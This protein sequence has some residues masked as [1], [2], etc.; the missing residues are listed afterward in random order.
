VTLPTPRFKDN[1]DGT[2]TDRLTGLIWLKNVECFPIGV[3]W[4]QA[5]RNANTLMSGGGNCNLT[6]G[7]RP[8]DW[9]VPNIRELLSLINFG[10]ADPAL[11]NTAGT[12]HWASGSP[13]VGDLTSLLVWTST[14]RQGSPT[15]AWIVYTNE[16]FTN[17]FPKA[18][19]TNVR[20]WPVRGG[21]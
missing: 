19:E 11:G 21:K 16:G 13:F 4:V 5:L 20:V 6:D 3:P 15:E 1:G 8:G 12:G 9:R 2:V 18:D 17:V 10:F 7:S 14:S